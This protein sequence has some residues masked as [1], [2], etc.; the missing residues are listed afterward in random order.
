L[1]LP[2]VRLQTTVYRG[3]NPRWSFDPESG[4]GAARYGGRFNPKGTPALYTSRRPE[5]AWLE[6]QQG[7][8]FK[9]QPLTLCA[10]TVDC[11]DILDLTTTAGR[12]AAA[13]SSLELHAAWEDAAGRGQTP[14]TWRLATSLIAVGCAGIVVPSFAAR[15]TEE[16]VN[17]VFWRWSL[18]LP[19]KV[20]VIDD[21][22]RLPRDD[23]SW[24]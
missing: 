14:P 3:H 1:R 19:H 16:D 6:A 5:T 2:F 21:E 13:A 17:L 23:R 22:G 7:F 15:A 8:P 4:E 9:A 10:Y 20:V 24:R 12:D 18:E 11:A